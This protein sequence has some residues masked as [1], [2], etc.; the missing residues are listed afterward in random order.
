MIANLRSI[1]LMLVSALT[2]SVQAGTASSG[3][4]ASITCGRVSQLYDLY[5]GQVR[6]NYIYPTVNVQPGDFVAN[7]IESIPDFGTKT[8]LR[9][10]FSQIIFNTQYLPPG[11]MM[12][13]PEDMGTDLAVLIPQ[14]CTLGAVGYYENSGKLLVSTDVLN[15]MDNLNKSA[16]LLHEVLYLAA[17]ETSSEKDSY[18]TRQVISALFAHNLSR[19]DKLRMLNGLLFQNESFVKRPGRIQVKIA[20]S[21]NLGAA[22]HILLAKGSL[23]SVGSILCLDEG[24]RFI[25]PAQ[26]FSDFNIDASNCAYIEVNV[27]QGDYKQLFDWTLQDQNGSVIFNAKTGYTNYDEDSRS[28]LLINRN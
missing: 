5:E 18:K 27:H 16:F 28:V 24:G 1:A 2:I 9:S 23:N 7:L 14:G 17:R 19:E 22:Q 15:K 21:F 13:H 10:R 12:E 11:I 3:G 26:R 4:G 8:L 20:G 6:N 25:H